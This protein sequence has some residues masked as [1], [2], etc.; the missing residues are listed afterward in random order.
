MSYDPTDREHE[1]RVEKTL[2]LWRKISEENAKV[3]GS[4]A[5]YLK[6]RRRRFN[7]K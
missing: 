4:V 1:R 6:E 7:E 2:A 5:Q 3:G